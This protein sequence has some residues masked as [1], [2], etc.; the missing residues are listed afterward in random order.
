MNTKTENFPKKETPSMP[1]LEIKR[2]NSLSFI[3]QSIQNYEDIGDEEAV[4]MLA[5]ILDHPEWKD[6]VFR[7]INQYKPHIQN[8]ENI[9]KRISEDYSKSK[10][11]IDTELKTEDEIWWTEHL[12]EMENR[13]ANLIFY[14]QPRE[15]TIVSKVI[16]VPCNQLLPLK[17]TGRS[18]RVGNVAI[19]M[20]HTE[21]PDNFEHEFLHSIINPMTARMKEKIPQEKVIALANNRHK[22]EGAYGNH[23][24]S[25]LN[26]ELIRTYNDLIKK[27]ESMQTFTDFENLF[28]SLDEGRFAK[29]V[30]SKSSTRARLKAMGISS[31][32]DFKHQI[33]E[34]YNRYEKNE[35]R[36]MIY[37]LYERFNAE[38]LAHP[39]TRFE[40][41]LSKEIEG[42]FV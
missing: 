2:E 17:D 3:A 35:L 41:F 15:N 11:S 14:F 10:Q 36:E 23:A 22:G 32:E 39:K 9:F 18:F 30:D 31:L 16:I 8:T 25:L 5:L 28:S 34:Y 26:E 1:Q 40:D 24:L 37:R 27:G 4:L 21:N 19:I 6:E 13:I 20:S 33:R 12:P 29:I 42:L 38:K 7:Q